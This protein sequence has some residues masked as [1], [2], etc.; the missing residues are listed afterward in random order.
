VFGLGWARLLRGVGT[1]GVGL[2]WWGKLGTMGS[3]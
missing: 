1:E 3:R 2:T